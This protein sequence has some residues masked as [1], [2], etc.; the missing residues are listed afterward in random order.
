MNPEGLPSCTEVLFGI[1]QHHPEQEVEN[2]QNQEASTINTTQDLLG[3]LLFS[4]ETLT[5]SETKAVPS[6]DHLTGPG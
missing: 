5:A 1:V 2:P 4:F 6:E 3:I